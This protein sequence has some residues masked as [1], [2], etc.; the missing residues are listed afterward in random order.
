MIKMAEYKNSFRNSYNNNTV[1]TFLD[2]F[3]SIGL[4]FIIP[5][6][7]Q[8]QLLVGV[9]VNAILFRTAIKHDLKHLVLATIV[10]SLGAVASGVLLGTL[11]QYLIYMVPFIWIGNFLLAYFVRI[12]FISKKL[13]YFVSTFVS[14]GIKSIFLFI[15]AF[16]LFYFSLVPIAFLTVFGIFQLGTAI[17][18]AIVIFVEMKIEHK[19]QNPKRS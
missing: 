17:A 13:N 6:L 8:H 19:I 1:I 10:P 14:A 18:G 2:F 7:L 15:S 3:V 9:I 5:I 12:F 16:T 11:T 4:L